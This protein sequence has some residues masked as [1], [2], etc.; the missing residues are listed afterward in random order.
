MRRN[1]HLAQMATYAAPVPVERR[2]QVLMRRN[3]NLVRV[4]RVWNV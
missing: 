2:A 3:G 1:G 4:V